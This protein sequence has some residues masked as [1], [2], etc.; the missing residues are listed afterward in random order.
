MVLGWLVRGRGAGRLVR[1]ATGP[2]VV[3]VLLVVDVGQDVVDDVDE[4]AVDVVLVV[5]VVVGELLRAGTVVAGVM[6]LVVV[7]VLVLAVALVVGGVGFSAV[8]R[9]LFSVASELAFGVESP[10][11]L[12]AALVDSSG[13]FP[14]IHRASYH[15]REPGRAI[16]QHEYRAFPV[17]SITVFPC[18]ISISGVIAFHRVFLFWKWSTGTDHALTWRRFWCSSPD[19]VYAGLMSGTPT[20]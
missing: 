2:R 4:V 6:V 17:S 19:G 1:L 5:L 14:T 8:G 12:R 9:Q 11:F 18:R 10:P 3:L 7:D 16:S 15:S 20:S 13:D